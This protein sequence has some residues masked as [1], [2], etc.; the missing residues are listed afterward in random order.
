MANTQWFAMLEDVSFVKRSLLLSFMFPLLLFRAGYRKLAET[1]FRFYLLFLLLRSYGEVVEGHERGHTAD[2]EPRRRFQ[3][4]VPED[5][6]F[7]YGG[8][9]GVAINLRRIL[10]GEERA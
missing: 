4:L 3:E 5:D 8:L 2:T 6:K 7:V 9:V 1:L 10:E